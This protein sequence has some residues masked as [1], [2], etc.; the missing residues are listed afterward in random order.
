MDLAKLLGHIV[1]KREHRVIRSIDELSDEELAA[2]EIDLAR[3]VGDGGSR[4]H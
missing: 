4:Q 3:R 2:L 1:E